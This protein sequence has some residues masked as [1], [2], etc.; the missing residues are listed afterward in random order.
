MYSVPD[1]ELRSQLRSDNV[2]LIVNRYK[3]FLA[4]YGKIE[5]STKSNKY[6]QYNLQ[7]VEAML[8]KFFDE[9]V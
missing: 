6:V 3:D 4:V 7:M 8:N 9:M 2:E 1:S 5:F